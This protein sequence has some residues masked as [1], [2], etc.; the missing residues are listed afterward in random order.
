MRYLSD[1][2]KLRLVFNDINNAEK[3]GVPTKDGKMVD[4]EHIPYKSFDEYIKE[5]PDCC[6]I[7]PPGGSDLAPPRFS[8]RIFGYHSGEP[9]V[10]NFK[11]RY[12]DDN[13]K[14]IIQKIRIDNSLQNCG[15]IFSWH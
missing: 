2:E 6:K 14:Q 10:I 9:I 13:D 8:D 15:K 7:K 1:E 12:I 5:N 11:V 3:L 4:R